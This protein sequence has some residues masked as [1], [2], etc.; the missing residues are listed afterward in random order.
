M[1]PQV[2]LRGRAFCQT[3][4]SRVLVAKWLGLAWL[5]LE[6]LKNPESRIK[7]HSGLI[8]VY[9]CMYVY[10]YIYIHTYYAYI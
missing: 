3:K 1:G 4:V 2:L 5:L 9:I 10:I 8:Q 6:N 7:N